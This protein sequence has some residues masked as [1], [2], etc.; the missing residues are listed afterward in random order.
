M[1]KT[2]QMLATKSDHVGDN[3]TEGGDKDL[4]WFNLYYIPPLIQHLK[5]QS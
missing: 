2:A 4:F 3:Q 5:T 1:R